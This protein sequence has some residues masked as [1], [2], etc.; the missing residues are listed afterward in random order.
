MS[1]V[2]SY[3]TEIR[4]E[5]ALGQGRSVEEDPGWEILDDAVRAT[6]EELGLEVVHAIRD[7]YGRSILCDWALTGPSFP[8]GVGVKVDR[9][10]GE[11]SFL[12]DTYGGFERVASQIKER[13]VQ[14]Y[15]AMCV[16]RALKELNYAVEVQEESHPIE[17]KKVLVRG[18]L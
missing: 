8:R 16:A 3:K 5:S 18:V 2:S 17:G 1:H 13:V 11:V 7:Y 4:L 10:T 12:A 14:N 6:A 9:T 15:T